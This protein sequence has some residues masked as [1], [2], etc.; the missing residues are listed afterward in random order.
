[1]WMVYVLE[2]CCGFGVCFGGMGYETGSLK[3]QRNITGI[4]PESSCVPSPSSKFL[5]A[6]P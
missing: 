3:I 6:T 5:M 1:M 4:S 2:F